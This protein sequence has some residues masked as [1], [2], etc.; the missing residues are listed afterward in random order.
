MF[1]LFVGKYLRL[2]WMNHM[3]SICFNCFKKLELFFQS[4][5]IILH[6]LQW[7]MR[8]PGAPH[9]LQ[10]LVWPGPFISAILIGV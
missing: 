10:H 1:L 7:C 8:V 3:E 5:C 2:A 9:P 6:L 4:G